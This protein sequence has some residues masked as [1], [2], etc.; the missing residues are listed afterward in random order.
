ML[1][2]AQPPYQYDKTIIFKAFLDFSI[3]RLSELSGFSVEMR[4]EM[5]QKYSHQSYESTALCHFNALAASLTIV[6]GALNIC[7]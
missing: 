1:L 2:T 5:S 3:F 6:A 4:V 7:R